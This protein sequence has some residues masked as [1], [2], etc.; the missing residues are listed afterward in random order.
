MR[1][2]RVVWRMTAALR[3]P[4][5]EWR[6]DDQ[7]TLEQVS[8]RTEAEY[9]EAVRLYQLYVC[10]ELHRRFIPD[11]LNLAY[12]ILI[13][14]GGTHRQAFDFVK[15]HFDAFVP[16][17]PALESKFAN[18][19]DDEV[20]SMRKNRPSLMDWLNSASNFCLDVDWLS[21]E[22]YRY[23]LFSDIPFDYQLPARRSIP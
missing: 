9:I 3:T 13:H 20:A 11:M 18:S 8:Y 10:E 14:Y 1:N 15:K 12:S 16:G 7:H 2:N 23:C 4:R 5:S 19:F 17:L 6:G 21:D 22:R